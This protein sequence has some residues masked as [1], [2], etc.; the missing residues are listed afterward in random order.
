MSLGVLCLETYYSSD[1][2][3]RRSVRGLLEVLEANV[4]GL[5]AVHR[6]VANKDDFEF[7]MMNDWVSDPRYDVLYIASHGKAGAVMDENNEYMST[8]WLGNRLADSCPG[9]VVY[10]SGCGTLDLSDQ[11]LASFVEATRATAVAGYAGDV[12]WLESAQMDLIALG[13]LA[14]EGPGATGVWD[15]PPVETLGRIHREHEGFAARLGWKCYAGGDASWEKPRR[16]IPDG[17]PKAVKA[18]GAIATDKSVEPKE[19]AR[20]IN[21]LAV[22]AERS[23][24][25]TFKTVADEQYADPSLRKAAIRGLGALPG[26]RVT[27]SLERLAEH[28]SSREES[29]SL[30]SAVRREL[31]RRPAP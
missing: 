25:K 6:H 11:V 27:N 3:D 15:S 13:A 10:L 31:D 5:W 8:R 23:S 21:A 22:L 14:D 20:A 9:R 12:D 2:D 26:K 1:P 17:T 4:S 30:Q 16:K 18:L 19:R 24:L 7:Y 28:F 29:P